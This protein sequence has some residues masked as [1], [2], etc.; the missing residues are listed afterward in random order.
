MPSSFAD[1]NMKENA[2]LCLL[3]KGEDKY[4][5]VR[6]KFEDYISDIGMAKKLTEN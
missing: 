4:Q 6:G 5:Q 1:N 2:V 3:A